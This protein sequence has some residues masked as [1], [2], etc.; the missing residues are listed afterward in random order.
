MWVA[1]AVHY[2]RLDTDI[3]DQHRRSGMDPRELFDRT[4]AAFNAHDAAAF[5]SNYSEEAHVFDPQYPEPMT[6]R[7]SIENDVAAFFV[8]FPDVHSK[9]TNVMV[10]G[11]TVAGEALVTGTHQGPLVTPDG[12]IPATGRRATTRFASFGTVGPDGTWV[13]ER[14]YY[15]LAGMMAQ[16]G[17]IG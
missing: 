11:A 14:R 6:G 16:L 5:A 15:D 8:A 1:G 9:V 10:D 17:L 4:I 13:E 7:V 3:Q 12:D 2:S